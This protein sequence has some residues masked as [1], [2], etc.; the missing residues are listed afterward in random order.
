MKHFK[1]LPKLGV[2]AA[3]IF[4]SLGVARAQGPDLPEGQGKD[5]VEQSCAVCHGL[6]LITAKRRTPDGW[7]DLL[8]RMVTSGAQL[9]DAQYGQVLNYLKTTLGTTA[10]P[11]SGNVAGKAPSAQA[12]TPGKVPPPNRAQGSVN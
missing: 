1:P 5:I 3:G 12:V 9:D 4:F 8:N 11:A 7:T 6:E 2:V 10:V